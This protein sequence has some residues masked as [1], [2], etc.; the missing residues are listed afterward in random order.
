ML[1]GE[2]TQYATARFEDWVQRVAKPG[3]LE[4]VS[5]QLQ[6]ALLMRESLSEKLS[7]WLDEKY[8]LSGRREL[9]TVGKDDLAMFAP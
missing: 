3:L 4:E 5:Q 8:T 1:D 6:V 9:F 2:L 7:F